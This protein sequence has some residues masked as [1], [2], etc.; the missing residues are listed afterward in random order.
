MKKQYIKEKNYVGTK[1]GLDEAV[2]VVLNCG[3]SFTMFRVDSL[4]DYNLVKYQIIHPCIECAPCKYN[5]AGE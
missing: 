2:E 4:S 3:H 5:K 1:G